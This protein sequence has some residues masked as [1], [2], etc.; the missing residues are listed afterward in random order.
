VAPGVP[1]LDVGAEGAWDR[2][3]VYPTHNP[4]IPVGEQL[5]I[6]YTGM[7][8]GTGVTG[9]NLT[10]TAAI[11]LMAVS[12]DRFAGMA[13]SRGAPGRL[14]TQPVEVSGD[15]LRINVE[16]GVFSNGTRVALKRPNGADVQG[17][18]LDDCDP[19]T[20]N[21]VRALVSW[22]G[23]SDISP[24]R[25]QQVALSFEIKGMSLYAFNFVK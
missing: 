4:P 23:G 5:Y 1:F 22:K 25:G 14:L 16:P 18:S 20:D 12:L 8:P 15:E 17:F 7:G 6:Y 19:V 11:G 9:G 13:N 3:L 24:L 2:C 21:A 10:Y